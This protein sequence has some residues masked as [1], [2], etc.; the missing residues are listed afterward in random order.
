M[1]RLRS[2]S[3]LAVV[4][5]LT[6]ISS[7]SSPSFG[8]R[9]TAVQ[10][11]VP[12]TG[13]TITLADSGPLPAS[14]GGIGAALLSGSVPGGQTGG[15]V[16]LAAGTL[17]SAVVGLVGTDAEA[18][19]ANVS[20][21]ISGNGI[22]VDFLMARSTA[23]CGAGPA[24]TGS[25]QLSNLVIN[26]QMIAVTGAANQT[27]ALPNGTAI[28]NEQLPSVAG[29]SG[30]LTVNALH[31]ATRDALT[32][33]PLADVV[34]ASADAEIQCLTGSALSTQS[35]WAQS[36]A[37]G[38]ASGGGWIPTPGGKATFGL[39][40]GVQQDS[41]VTGHIVYVDHGA[42]DF[43]MESTAITAFTATACTATFKGN[44]TATSG[45]MTGDVMF[46][47][48][49]QDNGEPG[50]NDNFTIQVSGAFTY[51]ASGTLA[52]GNLEVDGSFAGGKVLA[53]GN[54]C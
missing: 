39:V 37:S 47:V 31:V 23:G 13:T 38:F 27:V 16:S 11:L 20:L 51:S 18:S 48:T 44:G 15:L 19:L 25:S 41:T 8:G 24:V 33:Q 30:Q 40:A 3:T 22:T 6:L 28:I 36:T 52:G 50:R 14:G 26:G 17:H 32:G 53:H 9:A 46:Q 10:V 43:S 35:A 29:G 45:G 7:A 54:A 2:L 12:A 21:T 1:N 4:L 34:L 49:V 42:A 5:S